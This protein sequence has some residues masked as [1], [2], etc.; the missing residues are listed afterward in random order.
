ML[1]RSRYLQPG[2]EQAVSG[3]Q[4][5]SAAPSGSASTTA[6]DGAGSAARSAHGGMAACTEVFTSMGAATGSALEKEKNSNEVILLFFLIKSLQGKI[7]FQIKRNR[8]KGTSPEKYFC[9]RRIG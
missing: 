7:K 4:C 6:Q 8:S 3:A 9:I 1:P 2:R 5:A